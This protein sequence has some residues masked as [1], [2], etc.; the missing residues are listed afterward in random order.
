MYDKRAERLVS[1]VDQ[2]YSTLAKPV[3]EMISIVYGKK[4][5]YN[6]HVVRKIA[7]RIV[8]DMK[9]FILDRQHRQAFIFS[10]SRTVP[11]DVFTVKKRE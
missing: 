11:L 4:D 10:I 3:K 7:D 5:Q 2:I 9:S 1:E 8:K 6:A